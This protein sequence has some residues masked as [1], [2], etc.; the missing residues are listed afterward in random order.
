MDYETGRDECD[1][2]K[3]DQGMLNI[4]TDSKIVTELIE[5]LVKQDVALTSTL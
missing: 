1:P 5:H 4:A 3:M 2:F